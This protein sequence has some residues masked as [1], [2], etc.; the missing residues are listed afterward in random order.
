MRV[1]YPEDEASACAVQAGYRGW[2]G[3]RIARTE[4]WH[5][6]A[7]AAATLI[8][9]AWRRKVARYVQDHTRWRERGMALVRKHDPFFEQL[10]AQLE[11]ASAAALQRCW[12]GRRTRAFTQ[13]LWQL[14]RQKATMHIQREWRALLFQREAAFR[15]AHPP[16]RCGGGYVAPAYQGVH[17]SSRSS[18]GRE[19]E[20][21]Q[22]SRGATDRSARRRSQQVGTPCAT[23]A[24]AAAHP[25]TSARRPL[26]MAQDGV[27]PCGSGSRAAR[28][29][30]LS[31]LV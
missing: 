3:R 12:R 27:Q 7:D 6:R 9:R 1:V 8:A 16:K 31:V 10:R 30:L 26:T 5:V 20:R 4:L 28:S 11:H 25:K 24:S 22:P 29:L 14:R 21:Q 17:A 19:H 15:A 2:A 23:P 13:S 18:S